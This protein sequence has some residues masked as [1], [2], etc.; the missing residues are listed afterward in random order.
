[1]GESARTSTGD[2]TG[3]SVVVIGATGALGSAVAR[4]LAARHADVTLT[5]ATGEKLK[6]LE[7]D[8]AEHGG[9]AHIVNLRSDSEENANV[10]IESA[11]ER[12][13]FVDGL[14]V[15]SGTNK[16]AAITAMSVEQFDDVMN[17]NVRNTWLICRAF[18]GEL[19]KS[20]RGGSVVLVTSTRALLGHAAGYTAYCASKGAENLLTRTLAAEWGPS[21]I[22]VNA[23]APTVFRS[24][25]TAWMYTEEENAVKT[26]E[27]MLSRIPL[28]RL[29]EPDDIVGPT[30]FLLGD[31]AGFCTG[32][33]LYA[34]GGYTSC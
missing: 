10:I 9:S 33:I 6:E 29:A 11:V 2:F 13:G 17:A 23:V 24:D 5:G 25:L 19:L 15:A 12:F 31:D 27:G 4:Q 28:G 8:I 32:Q 20:G 16:V 22:R 14:I 26:R 3:R 34:D 7:R 1:M 21:S 30:L 18:G